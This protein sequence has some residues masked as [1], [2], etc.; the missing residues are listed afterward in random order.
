MTNLTRYG[1]DVDSAFSLLGRAENDLTAAL[2]FTLARCRAFSDILLKRIWP[3]L[4]DDA[5]PYFALEERAKVGRTDLEV[6]LPASAALLIF[7]AKRDWLLPTTAQLQQYVP[8]IHRYGAG[9]LI[10]LSQASKALASTQLPECIDG[11]PVIHLP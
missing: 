6:R 11:I 3:A 8:R 10:S 1:T 5:E 2:G 4:A 7:E 9:A